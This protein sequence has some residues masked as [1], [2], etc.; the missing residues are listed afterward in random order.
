MKNNYTKE[1]IEEIKELC[2][3]AFE[4]GD[5]FR[6]YLDKNA[7]GIANKGIPPS[8]VVLDTMN[9]DSWSKQHLK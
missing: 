4:A 7:I 5:K 6:L 1:Q 3:K 2:R 8:E 9:F